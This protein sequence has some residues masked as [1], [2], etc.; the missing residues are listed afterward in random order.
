[1]LDDMDGFP[2]LIGDQ[3]SSC[4][5]LALGKKGAPVLC[6]RSGKDLTSVTTEDPA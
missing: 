1:M 2:V 3:A 5:N 4:P 6:R